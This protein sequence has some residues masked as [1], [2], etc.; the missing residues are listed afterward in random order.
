M[1]HQISYRACL[2]CLACSENPGYAPD[3]LSAHCSTDDVFKS[4]VAYI[5][6]EL[7][8]SLFPAVP[9]GILTGG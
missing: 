2:A 8:L 4:R 5:S 6:D 3:M 1:S 7:T 9:A